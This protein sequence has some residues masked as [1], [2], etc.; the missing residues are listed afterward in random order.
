[1][2]VLVVGKGGR[3]HAL[4]KKISESSLLQKIWVAPGNAGMKRMGTLDC[5]PVES[6]PEILAF[7]ENTMWP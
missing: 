1:M 4:T 2:R 6:T 5:V 3:E 7:C